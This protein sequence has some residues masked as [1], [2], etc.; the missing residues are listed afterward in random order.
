MSTPNPLA[1]QGSL[2][3]QQ[4]RSKSSLQIAALIVGLHIFVIGGLLI[5]GCDK[6]KKQ[7][8]TESGTGSTLGSAVVP[9]TNLLSAAT[10][11]YASS[12]A[13]PLPTLPVYNPP[14]SNVPPVVAPVVPDRPPVVADTTPTASLAGATEYKVK[15]GDNPGKIAKAHGVT[16]KALLD[17]NAGLDPKKLKP[18]MTIQIPASSSTGTSTK[19]STTSGT[20]H[21]GDGSKTASTS[22]GETTEYTVKGGDNLSKIARKFGTTVKEIK[23]LNGLKD[24][25][26]TKGKKLKVPAK[27]VAETT[28]A[29]EV[30]YKNASNGTSNSVPPIS[31]R[32]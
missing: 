3:E 27:A 19:S 30:I 1:P 6:E 25:N 5:L 15:P 7:T 21:V 13:A 22:S 4:A 20:T 26:I 11:P 18:G 31:S 28:V 12:N 14:V 17:A 23:S 8:Q 2:L 32:P 9:D 29:P 16:T 10:D 24:N